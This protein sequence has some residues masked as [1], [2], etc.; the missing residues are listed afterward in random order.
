MGDRANLVEKYYITVFNFL[1][2][3]F[4]LKYFAIEVSKERFK[5]FELKKHD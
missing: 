4:M 5:C 2:I 3:L 1:L